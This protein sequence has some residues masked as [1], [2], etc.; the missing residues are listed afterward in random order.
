MWPAPVSCRRWRTA[1]H[2]RLLRKRTISTAANTNQK[3]SKRSFLSGGKMRRSWFSALMIFG[4]LG[5]RTARSSPLRELTCSVQNIAPAQ[6]GVKGKMGNES[7]SA[8]EM[9]ISSGLVGDAERHSTGAANKRDN[10]ADFWN[11]VKKSRT[12][13]FIVFYGRITYVD[14][15]GTSHWT[16]FCTR[17]GSAMGDLKKCVTYNDADTN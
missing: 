11:Y 2:S 8:S 12:A 4:I 16:S 14:I 15:F 17:A 7:L 3:A 10:R 9:S 13:S 5:S 6:L 1:C